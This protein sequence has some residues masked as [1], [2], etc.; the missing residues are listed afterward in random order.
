MCLVML[1]S[2]LYKFDK[3]KPFGGLF[4]GVEEFYDLLELS[5]IAEFEKTL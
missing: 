2:Y 3:D 4:V 1:F 5:A